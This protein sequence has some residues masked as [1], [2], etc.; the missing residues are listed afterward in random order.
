LAITKAYVEMMGGSI[1]LT[2]E[3]G[4]GSVFSFKIPLKYAEV[5]KI[6]VKPVKARKSEVHE[7]FTI[8]IAEDDNINFLLFQKI[9]QSRNCNIIRAVNGLEAVE[10]S[11]NNPDLD[12]VLMDIKMPI[13]NGYEALEKVKAIRPELLVVAQTAYSSSDD[14]ERIRNAGFFGYLTKPI[15]R[16][17][18][19]E[20][21]DQVQKNNKQDGR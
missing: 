14:E 21:I 4:K 13:M 18:L 11:L 15:N 20:I 17:K 2:S 12:L 7:A 6:S 1:S 10:I 19:F 8:L 3:V 16:E 5:Q 9:I